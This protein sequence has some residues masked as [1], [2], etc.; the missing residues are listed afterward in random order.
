[1]IYPN[2]K[3]AIADV[4]CAAPSPMSLHRSKTTARSLLR[5][6]PTHKKNKYQEVSAYE[7][8]VTYNPFVVTRFGGLGNHSLFMMPKTS[9]SGQDEGRCCR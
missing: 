8:A 9:C 1:M 3:G 5:R 4:T 2:G 7:N 6:N